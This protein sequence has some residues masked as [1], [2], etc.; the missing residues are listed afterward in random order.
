MLWYPR[1]RDIHLHNQQCLLFQADTWLQVPSARLTS[2]IS[3]PHPKSWMSPS[4]LKKRETPNSLDFEF[5]MDCVYRGV[6]IY[7]ET[8]SCS[9]WINV[10]TGVV[11]RCSLGRNSQELSELHLWRDHNIWW[12]IWRGGGLMSMYLLMRWLS[13]STSMSSSIHWQ[14]RWRSCSV[15]V[16]GIFK[17]EK[18]VF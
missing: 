16:M 2:L 7:Q 6:C 1:Y 17:V 3:Q 4:S 9:F 11:C 18:E 14:E 15:R 10:Q 8:S 12:C 5:S 13:S